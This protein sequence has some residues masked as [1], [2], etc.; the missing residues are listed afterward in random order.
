[1]AIL[2]GEHKRYNN[3]NDAWMR[4]GNTFVQFDEQIFYT[5]EIGSNMEIV[6]H[7]PSR[8]GSTISFNA[9][10]DRLN[11]TSLKLGFVNRVGQSKPTYLQRTPQRQQK[12]GVDLERIHYFCVD[13]GQVTHLSPDGQ[14]KTGVMKMFANDFPRLL[15]V[16]HSSAFSKT[17]AV[18]STSD[19]AV[20]GVFHRT[21]PVGVFIEKEKLFIFPEGTLTELR[22]RSLMNVLAKQ[23]KGDFNVIE[24]KSS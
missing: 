14:L 13:R 8:G 21:T 7:D 19:K 15:D 5:L 10:D 20:K 23:G 18:R 4:L 6:A 11:I 24:H 16:E 9:N 22:R 2:T 12:Q 17:W 1:M 3:A